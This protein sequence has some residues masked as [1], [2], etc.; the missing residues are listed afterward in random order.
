MLFCAELFNVAALCSNID[1]QFAQNNLQLSIQLLR[2]VP[3]KRLSFTRSGL[4]MK[5][6]KFY[7]NEGAN[8]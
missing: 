8:N 6:Y 1:L 3:E 7:V 4:I 5:S 2:Q